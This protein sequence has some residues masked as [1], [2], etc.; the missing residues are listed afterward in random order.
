MIT[1]DVSG[2]RGEGKTVTAM[3]I[4][5]LLRGLGFEVEYEGDTARHK[6][7]IEGMM[8]DGAATDLFAGS[9]LPRE[10]LVRDVTHG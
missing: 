5:K 7:I 6:S 8:A 9:T 4:V 2:P 10:F 3:R 1:I